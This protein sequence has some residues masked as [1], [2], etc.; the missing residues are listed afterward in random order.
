[1]ICAVSIFS[2]LISTI[3][4]DVTR[5]DFQRQLAMQMKLREIRLVKQPVAVRIVVE[6][7]FV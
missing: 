7:R 4:A 3:K 6:N 2:A 1:M 5:D